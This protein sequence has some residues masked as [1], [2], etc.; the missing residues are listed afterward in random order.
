[1][2]EQNKQP[3]RDEIWYGIHALVPATLMLMTQLRR[4]EP[5]WFEIIY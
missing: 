4:Q 5:M 2:L 3:R 1:M